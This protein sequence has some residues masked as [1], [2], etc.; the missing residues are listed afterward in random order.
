VHTKGSIADTDAILTQAT[1][2]PLGSA[3]FKAHLESRYLS[4]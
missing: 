2:A 1:G 3:A 4:S